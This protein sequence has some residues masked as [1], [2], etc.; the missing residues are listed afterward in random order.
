M[1]REDRVMK[2]SIFFAIIFFVG[3]AAGLIL[4]HGPLNA[5]NA[6]DEYGIM[7]KLDSI[8]K[9]QQELLAAVNSLKEDLQVVKIRVT[10]LQ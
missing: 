1:K 3:F 7:S 10:Q 4:T 8:A 9:G 5:Q 2:K 6:E